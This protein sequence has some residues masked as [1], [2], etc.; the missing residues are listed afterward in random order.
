MRYRL[1][2]LLIVL[3]ILPPLLAVGWVKYVAWKAEQEQRLARQARAAAQ[4]KI[5][6]APPVDW[7][8]KIPV[9]GALSE[10][11]LNKSKPATS[12]EPRNKNQTVQ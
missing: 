6:T 11:L 2:T 7:T 1:R 8:R 12:P 10:V 4:A 3:A 5:I 9:D